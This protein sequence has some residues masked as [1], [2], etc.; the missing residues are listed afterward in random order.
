MERYFL[1]H[2]FV[3]TIARRWQ[4]LVVILVYFGLTLTSFLLYVAIIRGSWSVTPIFTAFAAVCIAG[5]FMIGFRITYTNAAMLKVIKS[6]SK[7]VPDSHIYNW[8]QKQSSHNQANTS[9]SSEPLMDY[10]VLGGKAELLA[11][12][13]KKPIYWE[14]FGFALTPGVLKSLALATI[15]S[16]VGTVFSFIVSTLEAE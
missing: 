4:L 6:L 9:D 11:Y 10:E 16:I 14:V 5:L 15:T 13:K 2:Y 7:A 3:T 8:L 12:V 1:A